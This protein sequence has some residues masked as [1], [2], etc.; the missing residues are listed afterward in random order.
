MDDWGIGVT[1]RD[2]VLDSVRGSGRAS[3]EDSIWDTSR[4]S[5]R[6]LVWNSVLG[7]VRNSINESNQYPA[8]SLGVTRSKV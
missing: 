7:S 8:I 4:H 6:D 1:V 3:M 5:I 2:L